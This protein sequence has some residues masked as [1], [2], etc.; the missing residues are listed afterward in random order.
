MKG[1]NMGYSIKY[2]TPFRLVLATL[3]YENLEYYNFKPKF[4]LV[5]IIRYIL[6]FKK[7]FEYSNI[8]DY[9]LLIYNEIIINLYAKQ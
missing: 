7:I 8:N 2:I 1:Y 6:A 3:S 4:D 9:K 5:V